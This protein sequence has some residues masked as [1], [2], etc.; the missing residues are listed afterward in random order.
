MEC[1]RRKEFSTQFPLELQVQ[2][3]IGFEDSHVIGTGQTLLMS[4]REIVFRTDH[5]IE[6]E[7]YVELVIAWPVLLEDGVGLRLIV[8]GRV[9][10]AGNG[11]ITVS[12]SRYQFRTRSVAREPHAWNDTPVTSIGELLV[13]PGRAMREANA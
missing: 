3:K 4:S 5:R 6:P 1:P 11:T 10:A 7:T 8:Q 13:R 2:F 9:L 12:T